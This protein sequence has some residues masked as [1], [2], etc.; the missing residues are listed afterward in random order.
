MLTKYEVDYM[1]RMLGEQKVNKV[2]WESLYIV[3]FKEKDCFV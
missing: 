2:K 1:N 3:N